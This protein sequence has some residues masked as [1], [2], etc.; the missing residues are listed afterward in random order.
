MRLDSRSPDRELVY[1]SELFRA[2]RDDGRGEDDVIIAGNFNAGD[3]GLQPIEQKAGL[4]WVISGTSTNTNR[5]AQYDNVVF[6]P[7]ATVEF[8]QR[9][10]VFDFMKHYNLRLADAKRVSSH[11]PV[12]AEFNLQEGNASPAVANSQQNARF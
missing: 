5:T 8:N 7:A 1:L 12:W 10:G 4:T 11:L 9:G 2:I 6:N 3:R